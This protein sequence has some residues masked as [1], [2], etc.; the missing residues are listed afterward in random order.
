VVVVLLGNKM[1]W[2]EN[3]REKKSERKIEEWGSNTMHFA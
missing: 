2:N 3:R 1:V